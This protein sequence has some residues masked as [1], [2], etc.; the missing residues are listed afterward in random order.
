[1]GSV[2]LDLFVLSL[3]YIS[4]LENVSLT[5]TT[6]DTVVVT[7]QPFTSKVLAIET[8]VSRDLT[9]STVGRFDSPDE[10]SH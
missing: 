5:E 3:L 9:I 2:L 1:M 7:N 8:D 6:N 10:D 4:G